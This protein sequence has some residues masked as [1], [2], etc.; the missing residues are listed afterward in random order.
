MSWS[1]ETRF[2]IALTVD[3]KYCSMLK[4]LQFDLM[5]DLEYLP[6][7]V[8][9]TKKK[10]LHLTLFFLGHQSPETLCGFIE[11]MTKIQREF[12]QSIFQQPVLFASNQV[13]LF[14]TEKPTVI[15]LTGPYPKP[16]N[17][18]RDTVANCL[19]ETHIKPDLS[20]EVRGFLPHVTIGTLREATDLKNQ[21]VDITI[22]FTEMVL[23]KSEM[24]EPRSVT[25]TPL[26][27]WSL[28]E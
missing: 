1:K 18:L 11:A 15:A 12:F 10:R 5:D 25:H 20:H 24:I 16:L 7:S 2:F 26:C 3:E 17:H 22:C 6:H 23:F 4:E 27:S 28:V 14:P 13:Q 9:W 8:N 21:P 19:K